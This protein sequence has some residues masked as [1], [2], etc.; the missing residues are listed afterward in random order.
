MKTNQPPKRQRRVYPDVA[1]L[2]DRGHFLIFAPRAEEVHRQAATWFWDQEVFDFIAQQLHLME[3]HSLRSYWMAS[4]LKEA[5]MD[6][7]ASILSR[8]VSGAALE[9]AKL[10]ANPSFGS[11]KERAEAFVKSGW[12]C[13]GTYYN[14][15]FR[16]LA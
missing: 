10:K 14:R 11:E 4:E 3:N 9:V 7:K 16:K 15:H 8:C 13:R 12:G 1:A 5:G 6:W 2:E